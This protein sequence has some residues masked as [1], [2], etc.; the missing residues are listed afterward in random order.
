M[1]D[2]T[3][4]H[5]Q[6]AQTGWPFAASPRGP[7]GVSPRGPFAISPRGPFGVSP[8]GPFAI[9]PRGPFGVSPTGTAPA[10]AVAFDPFN[11]L[12]EP[13]RR[14]V[15]KELLKATPQRA[16]DIFYEDDDTIFVMRQGVQYRLST[17]VSQV[18]RRLG[19]SSL[20]EILEEVAAELKIEDASE[21]HRT[22][23][24]ALL[25]ADA[26]GLI[27]FYPEDS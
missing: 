10:Q 18:W 16:T 6:Q 4:P 26:A 24:Q 5:G 2:Q 15:M 13:I 12:P 11:W 19:Q 27:H 14:A 8:R 17:P 1:I 9:S 23:L 7:F 20:R 22:V 3:N 25:S 21:L